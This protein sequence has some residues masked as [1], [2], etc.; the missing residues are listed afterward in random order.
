MSQKTN[1]TYSQNG[2]ALTQKF[3]G[4][5]LTP[6]QDQVGVWTIGYGQREGRPPQLPLRGTAEQSLDEGHCFGCCGCQSPR[7]H[8][9]LAGWLR[10]L[11]Y[12]ISAK[13]TFIGD[14]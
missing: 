1:F 14:L 4:L 8:R 9:F 12:S 11:R 13:T 7:R 10:P 6:Y 2:L 5:R 3:E